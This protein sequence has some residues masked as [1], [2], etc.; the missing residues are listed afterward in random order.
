M[1]RQADRPNKYQCK[2]H[3]PDADRI[4][5]NSEWDLKHHVAESESSIEQ[6]QFVFAPPLLN[7]FRLDEREGVA[8]QVE[9]PGCTAREGEDPPPHSGGANS[10][11]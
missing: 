5:Q 11:P 8:M 2:Q 10:D 9:H 3:E 6:S 7:Q 1:H 4:G